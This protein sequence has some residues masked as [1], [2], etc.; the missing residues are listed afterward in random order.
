MTGVQ[1]CALPICV[2]KLLDFGIAKILE[3][4]GQEGQGESTMTMFRLLTPQYASPEQARGET[5]T[6]ASDVYSLGVVLYELLTGRSP[7][8][9]TSGAPQ[10]AARAVCEFEPVKPSTAVRVGKTRVGAAGLNSSSENKDHASS[11]D[12]LAKQLRGDLDNIILMALR[13]EPQRRYTSVEQF[14]ED[15]RRYLATLPVLARKD[16]P[17]DRK[18]VV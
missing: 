13:K 16:T 1:T 9:K 6:T 7:Y 12:K 14:A 2:P 18:S 4:E 8:P 17:R 15:I 11:Q 3:V 10:E 5:I